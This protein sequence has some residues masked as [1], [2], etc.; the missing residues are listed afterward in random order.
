MNLRM[1]ASFLQ[2]SDLKT[3][4]LPQSVSAK[5]RRDPGDAAKK[6]TPDSNVDNASVVPLSLSGAENKPK[7]E[8]AVLREQIDDLQ[9]KL[10]EKEEALRSAESS[11]TEMNAAYATIDELRRLVADK[12]ALI[13][14]TNSQLHDAKVTLLIVI[15]YSELATMLRPIKSV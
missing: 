8:V 9:K 10:L 1:D 11:V 14:S 6:S 2:A 7:D 3:V 12:E 15:H 13:R 4:K 5:K